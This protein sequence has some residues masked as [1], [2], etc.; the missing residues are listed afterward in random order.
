MLVGCPSS[1]WAKFCV[2]VVGMLLVMGMKELVVGDFIWRSKAEDRA[3]AS[4]LGDLNMAWL[5]WAGD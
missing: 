5:G 2:G 1:F 3:K 4:A